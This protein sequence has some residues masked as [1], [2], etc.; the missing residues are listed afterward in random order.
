M[1][2]PGPW[3]T[4]AVDGEA[5]YGTD[6]HGEHIVVVYELNTNKSDH[7]LIKAAPD[8][9]HALKNLYALVQGECPSL[10]EDDHHAMMVEN[11]IAKATR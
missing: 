10:L 11:A 1:H 4:D 2:T 3:Q 9:L 7:S 8:L 5:I 6:V